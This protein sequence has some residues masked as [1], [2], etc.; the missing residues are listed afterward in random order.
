VTTTSEIPVTTPSP[1]CSAPAVTI[2]LPVY[3]G[4]RYLRHSL[5]SLLAQSFTDFELIISDNSSTDGTAEICREYAERDQRIR[6]LRQPANIG[7]GPNHNILPP[8]ARAPYF[9]W[10]SHDDVYDVELLRKCMEVF[11]A[12]PE[13]TLVHCWDARI[14]PEGN[15]LPEHPYTLDTANPSPVARLRSLLYTDGGDDFY[16]VIR[17]DVL[18]RIGPHGSYFN[19]D[20]VY[21][22]GLSLYGPFYQVPEV[23]YFR[24]EHPNR[25][26]RAS[27]RDRAAGLDP[28]RRS[29]LRHPAARLYGEYLAGYYRTIRKAPLSAS[30]R[31]RCNLE[32]T[33]WAGGV[34]ARIVRTRRLHEPVT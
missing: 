24:R 28:V 13:A 4:E 9:K 14:D 8:M 29:R 2:G 5:D 3:N 21:V 20:R 16:G 6:Y 11:R 18:N 1:E 22:A 7:A 27:T 25:L 15:R 32:V 10:A 30:E 12:H 33:R 19:A 26:S 34:T 23:L 31:W 17:T